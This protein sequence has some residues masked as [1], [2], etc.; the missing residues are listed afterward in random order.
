MSFPITVEV[1]LTVRDDAEAE[2]IFEAAAN[3][4]AE[5]AIKDRVL[6]GG[7]VNRNTAVAQ[8]AFTSSAKADEVS[9]TL[10]PVEVKPTKAK[11]AVP[12]EVKPERSRGI[13][14]RRQ[15]NRTGGK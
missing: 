14:G 2:A 3:G 4:L 12:A 10:K 5:L 9:Q 15:M 7:V 6:Y 13:M 8:P 1:T 11:I